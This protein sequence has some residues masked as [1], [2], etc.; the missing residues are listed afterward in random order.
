MVTDGSVSFGLGDQA[1]GPFNLRSSLVTPGADDDGY[2]FS[3]GI[4]TFELSIPRGSSQTTERK[5][6]IGQFLISTWHLKRLPCSICRKTIYSYLIMPQVL[7]AVVTAT[8]VNLVAG[9]VAIGGVVA[10]QK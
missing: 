10:V 3:A 4:S 5:M 6:Q 9:V 1:L 2:M 8:V 7:P